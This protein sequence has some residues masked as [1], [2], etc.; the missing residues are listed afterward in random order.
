MSCI[1]PTVVRRGSSAFLAPCGKCSQCIASKVSEYTF[2]YQKEWLKPVYASS[3]ASFLCLTYDDSN[4]PVSPKGYMS[5]KI[6]DLQRFFKRFRI[7]LSRIGY[8][9]PIK[10]ISCTEYGG[11]NGRPHCH[12][13]ILGVPPVL[14]ADIAR[15]SWTDKHYGGLIDVKPLNIGGVS[16]CL[17]YLSK[18]KPLGKIKEEYEKRECE[19]PR[20][21]ISKGL[22]VD[23]IRNHCKEIVDNKF[24]FLQNGV[25][26]LYSRKVRDY[27][28]AYTGVDPR[29]YVND[30]MSKIDTHGMP[31]DDFNSIRD[32]YHA[33][34]EYFKNIQ[35]GQS[36]FQLI[37]CR[38]PPRMRSIGSQNINDL[39]NA[40]D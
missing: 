3:G 32:Y 37:N 31:L 21:L 25:T 13:S 29:P 38:L 8:D 12:A 36:S 1:S 19:T 7:N 11:D 15:K 24:T 35:N 2:L 10:Y 14:C 6:D 4:V 33:R 16:Y 40:I 20:V 17:K 23:W 30:Y 26:H 18:Q 27:V 5:T 28:E 34:D 9:I 39:I 22:G